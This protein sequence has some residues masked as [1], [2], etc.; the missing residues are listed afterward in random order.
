MHSPLSAWAVQT[1]GLVE[2][3]PSMYAKKDH[4]RAPLHDMEEALGRSWSLA[5]V[6]VASYVPDGQNK[7]N[8]VPIF[9]GSDMEDNRVPSL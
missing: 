9:V 1:T 4:D 7:P 8:K 5:K 3:Y 6:V 2:I